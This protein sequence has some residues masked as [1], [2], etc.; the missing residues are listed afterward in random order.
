MSVGGSVL[1]STEAGVRDKT[2]GSYCGYIQH[3]ETV[4]SRNRRRGMENLR[5]IE[6][7]AMR[8][9]SSRDARRRRLGRLKTACSSG[10][11]CA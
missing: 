10:R 2:S 9:A 11:G 1:L 3:L 4:R 8:R 7:C 5:E 6:T